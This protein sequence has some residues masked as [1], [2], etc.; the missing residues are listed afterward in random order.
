MEQLHINCTMTAGQPNA[1]GS[2]FVFFSSHIPKLKNPKEL[3][4]QRIKTLK[5]MDNSATIGRT[6]APNSV[7]EE[8]QNHRDSQREN[9][10]RIAIRE[11]ETNDMWDNKLL[12]QVFGQPHAM[13]LE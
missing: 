4:S 6:P 2:R 8:I 7:V 1:F 11:I 9:I 3:P 13:Y 12:P 5:K 10:V